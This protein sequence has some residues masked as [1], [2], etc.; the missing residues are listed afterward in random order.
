MNRTVVFFHAHPDDEALLTGGTMARLAAEGHRVVLVTATAGEAGLASAELSAGDRLGE[1]SAAR[2]VEIGRD[3]RLRARRPPGYADS[4]TAG[5]PSG[6]ENAFARIDPEP[7]PRAG[8]PT[9]S[10]RKAPPR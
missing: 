7:R 2:V 8:S 9:C 1:C 4:G 10:T 6:A 5:R 3:P